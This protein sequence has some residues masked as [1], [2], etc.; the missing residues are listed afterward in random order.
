MQLN[1][2]AYDLFENTAMILWC[3]TTDRSY[4]TFRD[5]PTNNSVPVLLDG[6]SRLGVTHGNSR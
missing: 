1:Y 4:V 5:E 6:E 2:V 3:Y